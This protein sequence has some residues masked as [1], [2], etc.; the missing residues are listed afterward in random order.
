MDLF[1]LYGRYHSA[2]FV[3]TIFLEKEDRTVK[4]KLRIKE[5]NA[6]R[7]LSESQPSLYKRIYIVKYVAANL[8]EG[9]SRKSSAFFMRELKQ[10]PDPTK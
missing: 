6:E 4:L 7:Y 2:G 10:K 5:K 1:Y 3:I 8:R 9:L